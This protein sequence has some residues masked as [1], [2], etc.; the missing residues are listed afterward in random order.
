[1][2]A[3]F[4]LCAQIE[5]LVA[6]KDESVLTLM[7][8]AG[9]QPLGARLKIVVELGKLRSRKPTGSANPHTSQSTLDEVAGMLLNH[10]VPMFEPSEHVVP[11]LAFEVGEFPPVNTA[12]DIVDE[13]LYIDVVPQPGD[14]VDDDGGG[15]SDESECL[16]V[17]TDDRDS[18]G[19]SGGNDL[20]SPSSFMPS[21]VP[22]IG[23]QAAVGADGRISGDVDKAAE[24]AA[25]RPPLLGGIHASIGSNV[26]DAGSPT[27]D[28]EDMLDAGTHNLGSSAILRNGTAESVAASTTVPLRKPELLK[29]FFTVNLNRA[30]S[31][32]LGIALGDAKPNQGLP[33]LNVAALGQ[34]A[35]ALEVG[36]FVTKINLENVLGK[37]LRYATN[38][39]KRRTAIRFD[40][41]RLTEGKVIPMV[42]SVEDVWSS[43]MPT[44][45]LLPTNAIISCF[46]QTEL[47]PD[48][49][50]KVWRDA[51]NVE[52]PLDLTNFDEFQ[53]M[54]A[55]CKA[56]GGKPISM[57]DLC[58]SP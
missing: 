40:V 25:N 3:I 6:V 23:R 22:S 1:L 26:K 42:D 17:A 36:D 46:K 5:S 34:G 15:E 7:E 52:P 54:C 20:K 50:R 12:Y 14:G 41:L 51:K 45:G 28:D 32:K 35:I 43:L 31:Q 13:D 8:A 19:N 55:L 24:V 53:R 29:Y 21:Y 10:A 44:N 16:E 2:V 9:I 56:A 57:A 27:Q 37:T 33:V 48:S 4:R 47:T 49:L 39:M 58:P 30:S 11:N 18:S 38:I